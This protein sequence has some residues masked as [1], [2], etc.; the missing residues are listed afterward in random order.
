MF[1]ALTLDSKPYEWFQKLDAP[2][3][4]YYDRAINSEKYRSF[5]FGNDLA[6]GWAS[7]AT[8]APA[9]SST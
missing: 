3:Q 6:T 8:M 1:D 5:R 2:D 4:E 7:A 9:R